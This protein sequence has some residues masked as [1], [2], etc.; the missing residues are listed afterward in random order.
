MVDSLSEYFGSG[1][2]MP[3]GHCFLWTPSL[4]WT[5]VVSNLIIAASYFS[6][7]FALWY[8]VQKRRDL[9][10][11]WMFSMFGAFV[12]ACGST[13]LLAVW[14]IWHAHYWADAGIKAF[15]AIASAATAILLW[16]LIPKALTMPTQEQIETSNRGLLSEIMRRERAESALRLANEALERRVAE[17]TAEIEVAND[18][19]RKSEARF[20]SL[21]AMSSDFYWETDAGH[22]FTQGNWDAN[23]NVA[24]VWRA[25][26]GEHRW[27][28]PSLSPDEA[29][30]NAHRAALDA[31]LPF[32][33]FR[34]SR[35]GPGG[36]EHHLS[37]SGDPLFDPS[38]AFLGYRGVGTDIT[39]RRQAEKRLQESE[40]RLRAIF[41][42]ALDGI[43]VASASTGK[44]LAANPAICRMLGYLPE[45]MS[46]LGI[47]DIHREKDLPQAMEQF[48][49]LRRGEIEMATEIPVLRKD[50]SVLHVDIKAAPVRLGDRECVL[51][52]F[53]DV[54]ERK[55][56]E[57]ALRAAEEQF[58]GLVE[59][60][61]A[62]IY[63][64][65]EDERLAYVNPRYAEIFG[66]D[67]ADELIG[68]D[69]LSLVAEKDHTIQAERLRQRLQGVAAGAN[70]S[71]TGVRKDGTV[72]DVEV[73]G[74]RA[75]HRGRPAVIG[76]LQDVSE[77]RRSE[78]QIGHYVTQ[79]E[80]T[81]MGTVNVATTLSEMRDPYTA[82]HERRV[83]GIAVAIGAELGFDAR[84]LEALRVA[85]YLHDIGKM[86]VP[87]EILSKPG[88]LAPIEM[89]LIQQHSQASYDV[90]KDVEFPWPV[91]EIALQ[92]HERM[93][94]SGYPLGL[95]GEAILLEARIMA[96]ADTVEAMSSHRPYRPGLGVDKAMAEIERGRGI[97]YDADVA[98]A[99]L[100]LF[101]DKRYQLPA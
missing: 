97:V 52:I 90:L 63:I 94:G 1:G 68:R 74:A 24:P 71:F 45:Q 13:H 93:D 15:T 78:E 77:K 50:G 3:H 48:E 26:I 42:G 96:V 75:T 73:Q 35:L 67:S 98:D 81:L 95:K 4:L 2:F 82:G 20:R 32:R 83:A 14:N 16:V 59:Q 56:S 80:K 62:G 7:P 57:K 51:G 21:T 18:S 53:R 19:L 6:I 11:P 17:R 61:I 72:V 44:F 12:L 100:R 89:Q 60:S 70:A 64:I 54:T 79:L 85:G 49:R 101:R 86:T 65:Q 23:V 37:L 58:R 92:H 10:F 47:A 46:G 8:F 5:Y 39:E 38:G 87:A 66:Y 30:W 28:R 31:H 99:C 91:A 34:I 27:D 76:L 41:E 84:R 69:A 55:Q 36:T 9:P 33:D 43:L 25:K 88:K 29:A 40:E 22:R